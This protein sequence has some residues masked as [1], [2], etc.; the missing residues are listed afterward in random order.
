MIPVIL[1]FVCISNAYAG[2]FRTL[3]SGTTQDLHAIWGADENNVYAV[4]NSGVVIYFNGNAWTSMNSGVSTSLNGIWG[5]NESEV[6]VVGNGGII[7]YYDGSSWSRMTS[8]TDNDLNAVWGI[9]DSLIYACGDSGTLL[10]YDGADWT[11]V[12]SGLSQN[13]NAIHGASLSSIYAVGKNNSVLSYNGSAWLTSY[14]SNGSHYNGV[15]A[16]SSSNVFVAG[17]GGMIMRYNGSQW[18]SMSSPLSVQYNGLW[19]SSGSNLYLVGVS[20]AILHYNGT[21]WQEVLNDTDE[22]LSA[23]W[24]Y[25]NDVFVAGKNG[26]VLIYD[27]SIDPG[28]VQF[29]SSEYDVDENGGPVTVYLSRSGGTNGAVSVQYEISGGNATSGSDFTP[30]SGTLTWG[31]G[32]SSDKSFEVYPIDDDLEELDETIKI[33]IQNPTGGVDIGGRD[34]TVVT[35]LD[36]ESAAGGRVR[37]S[38]ESYV[39]NEDAESIV[40]TVLRSGGSEGNFAVNYQTQNITASS[41]KDYTSTSGALSW[42]SGDANSKTFTVPI[43]DDSLTESDET[44]LLQLSG[45]V[46]TAKLG[47]PSSAQIKIMDDDEPVNGVLS[48]SSA[49]YEVREN[50]STAVITVTR[51]SGAVGNVT[52]DYTANTGTASSGSDYTPKT[53]TLS[54]GSGD[55]SDKTFSM[56]ILNDST[57]ESPEYITLTLTNPTGNAMLGD[58]A[59]ANLNII[60]DESLL[61]GL[62]RFDKD[63]YV[64]DESNDTIVLTVKRTEASEGDVTVKYATE[65]K[66]ATEGDDYK[67]A[68]GTLSWDSDNN[69]DKTITVTIYSDKENEVN[70]TFT[71][72]LYGPTGGVSLTSPTS[73]VVT[74]MNRL[75]LEAPEQIS[76]LSGAVIYSDQTLFKWLSVPN[77][78][79]YTF[80]LDCYNCCRSGKWCSEVNQVYK[81]VTGITDF[82]YSMEVASENMKRW[83]IAAVGINGDLG[84]ASPWQEFEVVKQENPETCVLNASETSGAAPLSV[85]FTVSDLAYSTTESMTWNTGDGALYRS[86]KPTLDHAYTASG[87]Y[88]AEFTLTE[89]NGKIWNCA[90]SITVTSGSPSYER[91]EIMP[92]ALSLSKIQDTATIAA[93]VY[94]TDGNWISPASLQFQSSN[95]SVFKVQGNTVTAVGNGSAELTLT[96]GGLTASVPVTV[97]N[98][99]VGATVSPAVLFMVKDAKSEADD[100]TVLNHYSDGRTEKISNVICGYSPGYGTESTIVSLNGVRFT[101]KKNG[102]A[103][104]RCGDGTN[105]GD[106]L[107]NV[108]SKMP[109]TASPA[110]LSVGTGELAEVILIGGTPP[111]YIEKGYI[112]SSDNIWHITA[113]SEEGSYVYSATDGDGDSSGVILN[114]YTPL[115]IAPSGGKRDGGAQ[116]LTVTGGSPPFTWNSIYGNINPKTTAGRSA[117]TYTPPDSPFTD[118][119]WVM[120]KNGNSVFHVLPDKNLLTVFPLLLQVPLGGAGIFK[121]AGESPPIALQWSIMTAMHEVASVG[122]SY[123]RFSSPQ[124]PGAYYAVISDDTTARRKVTA[125]VSP[126][127]SIFPNIVILSPLENRTFPILGW[128]RISENYSVVALRG[129][130]ALSGTEAAIDYT[131]PQSIGSDFIMLLHKNGAVATAE[132]QITDEAFYIYPNHATV[133]TEQSMLLSAVGSL[134]SLSWEAN[135]GAVNP[136]DADKRHVTYTAPSVTGTYAVTAVNEISDSNLQSAI[137]DMF[138]ISHALTLTPEEVFVSPG[139]TITLKAAYGAGGYKTLVHSGSFTASDIDGDGDKETIEYTAPLEKG[140]YAVAV[141][142]ASGLW[143][144]AMIYVTG[145]TVPSEKIVHTVSS[146]EAEPIALIQ[147]VGV[148]GVQTGGTAFDMKALFPEYDSFDG[149]SLPM[150]YYLLLT[151]FGMD[152]GFSAAGDV[153][154]PEFLSPVASESK[155]LSLTDVFSIDL[156][157][158]FVILPEGTYTVKAVSVE[159]RYDSGKNMAFIQQNVPYEQWEYAF[160]FDGCKTEPPIPHDPVPADIIISPLDSDTFEEGDSI[161]FALDNTVSSKISSVSWIS[162]KSGVIGESASFFLSN[163]PVGTHVIGVT[164]ELTT[165]DVYTDSVSITVTEKSDTTP[166]TQPSDIL[167]PMNGGIYYEG[168][169]IEFELSLSGSNGGIKSITWI[170]GID[171]KIGSGYYFVRNDLSLGKHSVTVFIIDNDNNVET[172]SISMTIRSGDYLNVSIT[173]PSTLSVIDNGKDI[174]FEGDVTDFSGNPVDNPDVTWVSSLDGIIG[175][176]LSF[177]R[178]DLSVGKHIIILSVKSTGGKSYDGKIN[179]TVR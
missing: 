123:Y 103:H 165:E 50:V 174:H 1:F 99:I 87:V 83:K 145:N 40:I 44:I 56:T 96:M 3:V 94:L 173:S 8:G 146:P 2:G 108:T 98:A 158:P 32:V 9:N 78:A 147:P 14:P 140:Q 30:L 41:G 118:T 77:A 42:A 39:V 80:T 119:L 84:P 91:I 92:G 169:E 34:E 79:S 89:E 33:K 47:S 71:V 7:L 63:A 52:V 85:S 81:E 28:T 176:T 66:T 142:D 38:A 109:F 171:G 17:D 172:H 11:A 132:V 131:A 82:Y 24:G 54:W 16:L 155:G 55:S 18:I 100:I 57:E 156:C 62:I 86:L 13:L 61:H 134:V 127:L 111:Y 179:I 139:G 152:F 122:G 124:S 106:F 76:P 15:V 68:S 93:K 104:V 160:S 159:S 125:E 43:L 129:S 135:F 72:N 64:V 26:A 4:G 37:F 164:A 166:D 120:D 102:L 168:Q 67:K 70:E 31:D 150:N 157:T 115:Q 167:S 170:S 59:T 163:L 53:G 35:I 121:A 88:E 6:Y 46:G 51:T 138:V 107:V 175:S 97:N 60:D 19:G 148:G 113:P 22:T 128:D 151:V 177:S 69:D 20:G 48:F 178:S 49:S 58:I 162:D 105:M 45:V 12:E 101:A 29:K 117:V 10:Q 23:V 154:P 116:A 149:L 133:Y 25:E 143:T 130:A 153:L 114:V 137:S 27:D 90:K 74:I 75:A 5:V 126:G 36:D 141:M 73:A 112:T 65:E 144:E 161:R 21:T 136:L 110:S 95:A